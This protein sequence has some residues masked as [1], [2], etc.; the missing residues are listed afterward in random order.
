M[1]DIADS[2]EVYLAGVRI[3]AAIK[4]IRKRFFAFLTAAQMFFY[5][6]E[7]KLFE[8]ENCGF[9]WV[10]DLPTR[11]KEFNFSSWRRHI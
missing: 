10:I 7:E 4:N 11:V 1:M 5:L 6:R 3:F 8:H 9:S 2:C